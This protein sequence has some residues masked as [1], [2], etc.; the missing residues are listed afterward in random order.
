MC[1][2]I[3]AHMAELIQLKTSAAK[4]PQILEQSE[5]K[6]RSILEK[7]QYEFMGKHG[8]VKTCHYTKTSLHGGTTC[9]K[10]QFYGIQSH[11][12]IQMSP[13]VDH[14]N[15]NCTFCWR[16]ME[17]APGGELSW[18][19]SDD[20]KMLVEQS[21]Q[22]QIKQLIGFKGDPNTDAQKV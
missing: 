22:A 11:Q 4:Q 9:Y 17:Y 5:S 19:E 3:N 13:I 12:C 2:L 10:Q 8:A 1:A 6:V 16:P 21:I 20:P 18:N 14:C 7:Q 15:Y